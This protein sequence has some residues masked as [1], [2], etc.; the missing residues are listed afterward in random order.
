MRDLFLEPFF[1]TSSSEVGQTTPNSD[2]DTSIRGVPEIS[3]LTN[4]ST[5]HLKTKTQ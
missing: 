5:E 3:G 1:R 2:P 4:G